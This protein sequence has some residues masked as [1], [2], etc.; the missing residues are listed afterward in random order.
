MVFVS[1]FQRAWSI[2]APP[3]Q[4]V[5]VLR[6]L[7]FPYSDLLVELMKCFQRLQLNIQQ[8]QAVPNSTDILDK[9]ISLPLVLWNTQSIPWNCRSGCT[10]TCNSL[11]SHSVIHCITTLLV[12][13][14]LNSSFN[15]TVLSYRSTVLRTHSKQYTQFPG[16][17]KYPSLTCPW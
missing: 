7:R 14:V 3:E 10:C 4:E 5:S 8:C 13:V 12:H 6:S 1:V 16:P 11:H 15:R 2:P 9:H 17:R